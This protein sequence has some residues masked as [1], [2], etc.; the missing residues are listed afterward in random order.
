M[1]RVLDEGLPCHRQRQHKSMEREGIQQR[2]E[3]VLIE[4]HEAH[5]HERSGEQVGDVEYEAAH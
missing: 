5:Q 4:H 3:P 2:I 1:W